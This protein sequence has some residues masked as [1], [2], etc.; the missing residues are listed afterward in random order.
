MAQ[1]MTQ[2]SSPVFDDIE[3]F[4]EHDSTPA[5]PTQ[6]TRRPLRE[7]DTPAGDQFSGLNMTA[8]LLQMAER[9]P[10]AQPQKTSRELKLEERRQ[11]LDAKRRDGDTSRP[12]SVA[13]S[14]GST[15]PRPPQ[16][17]PPNRFSQ[18]QPSL[19]PAPHYDQP[20]PT[21]H[22][23]VPMDPPPYPQWTD[24]RQLPGPVRTHRSLPEPEVPT[25]QRPPLRRTKSVA[26]RELPIVPV[27]SP[28][29]QAAHALQRHAAT[30][31]NDLRA[32]PAVDRPGRPGVCGPTSPPPALPAPAARHSPVAHPFHTLPCCRA[33]LGRLIGLGAHQT[34]KRASSVRHLCA[35]TPRPFLSHITTTDKIDWYRLT[36]ASHPSNSTTSPA[37]TSAT[38]KGDKLANSQHQRHLTFTISSH[39]LLSD[40]LTHLIS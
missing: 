12:Q 9:G 23:D 13:A 24:A 15:Q 29:L 17:H 25:T 7:L 2:P 27:N 8:Y 20:R 11:R 5:R 38:H 36:Y 14:S 26:A 35:T 18:P 6:S 33:Q 39:P 1:P 37:F 31:A 4:G 30:R 19:Q 3:Q 32:H 21:Q 34:L 40:L 10:Q 16:R 22:N 28:S